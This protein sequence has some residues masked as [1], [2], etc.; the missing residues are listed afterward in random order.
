MKNFGLFLI[1]ALLSM[2][3][4]YAMDAAKVKLTDAQIQAQLADLF[5]LQ[6]EQIDAN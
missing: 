2:S 1:L 5:R 3:G 6:P 4:L